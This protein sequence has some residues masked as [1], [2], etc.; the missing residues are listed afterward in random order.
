[1]IPISYN[2]R[3]L[4]TRRAT[5]AATAL[6]IALVVF[7]F[8]SAQML[9]QGLDNLLST[10]GSPGNAIVMRKGA[11]AE[12]SSNVAQKDVNLIFAAP[13]VKKNSEGKPIGVAEIVMVITQEKSGAPGI[14]NVTVRGVPANVFE[15]RS[16]AKIVKGRQAKPGTNEVVV[17][18][19]IAGRLKGVKYNGTFNLK[20]NRPVK[21]VGIF[22]AGGSTFESEVWADVEQVRSAFGRQGSV[23][24]VS[25]ALESPSKYDAFQ[26]AIEADKQIG[27]E[28]MRESRY[29]EKQSEMMMQFLGILGIVIAV[30]FMIGGVIGAMITMYSAVSQRSK[31]IGTLRAL[32]FSRLAIL[33]SFLLES[34][35]LA[36]VGGL[37]GALASLAMGMVEFA[38]VNFA[39]WSE[40][41]FTFDATP[42]I[43]LNSVK[44]GAIL[45]IIGGLFPAIK[46]AR[47]N[48]IEA[49]RS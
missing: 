2:I 5:T 16:H 11:D 14:S 34:L 6:G 4:T 12:L 23:S 8:S 17:G 10:T 13:G 24:S 44:W 43:L 30:F 35:I 31:E 19:R 20:K 21:V 47:T 22:S 15:F 25:V 40:I 37:V 33:G 27:L 36:A 18:K 7:V 48:P 46:A 42:G 1:M 45:G 9:T 32:G 28:A 38:T 29:Y 41:V 39:T 49:M 3:S 26:I